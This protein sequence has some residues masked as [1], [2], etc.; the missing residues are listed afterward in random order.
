V[1]AGIRAACLFALADPTAACLLTV[2]ALAVGRQGFT[3][4]RRTI[5]H[6]AD[7]LLPCHALSPEGERLPAL[8]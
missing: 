5:S 8:I 3:Y 4:C 1:A 6:F 2:D 7:L